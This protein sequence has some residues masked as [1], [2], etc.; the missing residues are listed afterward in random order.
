[1]NG[2]P[3]IHWWWTSK[4]TGYIVISECNNR[5]YVLC[6]TG[7]DLKPWQFFVMMLL[8]WLLLPPAPF[9]SSKPAAVTPKLVTT[10]DIEDVAS[11]LV[12]VATDDIDDQDV[13]MPAAAEK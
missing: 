4:N 6:Q 5:L 7:V 12:L 11:V 1:M 9:P 3:N 10:A 2:T 8:A 13:S